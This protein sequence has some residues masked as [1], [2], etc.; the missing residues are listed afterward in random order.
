MNLYT[1]IINFLKFNNN[2]NIKIQ[3]YKSKIK[4]VLCLI[5]FVV[6]SYI[7]YKLIKTNN[8]NTN[9]IKTYNTFETF[10]TPSFNL[11]I[12]NWDNGSGFFS[13]LAFKLNH[14]LYCK[15]YNIGYDT[16]SD[17]WPYKYKHGWTDYFENVSLI[18]NMDTQNIK[19][20][21]LNG[22]CTILEQF[23][24]RDYVSI[25]NNGE[26]YK[27]NATTQQHID[28]V[29]HDLGLVDKLY[30]AIYI[31]R[32]DKLVNEIKFIPSSKF[33][34]LLL[35]K[36]PD[37]T[38]IFIQTD[39][40]NSYLEV[41]EYITT[42]NL[43]IKV[44]TLCPETNFGAIAHGGYTDQMINNQIST[45]K[46]GTEILNDNK[47]YLKQIKHNLTKP[48][49]EMTPD[50]RYEHTMELITSIDI[51]IK[52]KICVC[53]YKSNVSRFIKLAHH[54]FDAVFDVMGTDSLISLDSLK[55]PGFDFDSKFNN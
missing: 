12:S 34:K 55:C 52:S 15:K 9:T 38:V 42:N 3:L 21:T 45:L 19:T 36:Y 16:N 53:D 18:N 35:E 51:C 17:N 7:F 31:R 4:L 32:G 26:Y 47:E 50:E 48:I 37:C 33:V 1:Q 44:L 54:N 25:I 8:I 14:Y 20:H 23:P 10:E 30:G 2:I 43:N 40:Y 49:A 11:L 13:E 24:L 28:R 27:Y 29:K 46:E 41:K 39:D 22:C 5:T 6:L